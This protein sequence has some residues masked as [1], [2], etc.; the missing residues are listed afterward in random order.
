M[1]RRLESMFGNLES[2]RWTPGT[3]M[4]SKQQ[5]REKNRVHLPRRAPSSNLRR[6]MGDT[7]RS[8]NVRRATWT[9]QQRTKGDDLQF[10]SPPNGH[11]RHKSIDC[12]DG[13]RAKGDGR[14]AKGEGRDCRKFAATI[15]DSRKIKLGPLFW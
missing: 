15:K 2:I 1:E 3:E 11:G 14:R 7:N 8:R 13:R 10:R 9:K 6:A 12:G 4:E 5:P